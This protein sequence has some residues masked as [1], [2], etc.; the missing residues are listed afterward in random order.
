[1]K[2]RILYL[3]AQLGAGGLERQLSYLLQ[4]IDRERHQ[5]AVVVWNYNKD[6]LYVQKISELGIPL[7]PLPSRFNKLEKLRAFRNLVKTCHP[8]IVHSYSFYTNFAVWF[9]TLKTSAIPIG[10]IRQNFVSERQKAG[11]VLGRLSARWPATQIC[12]SEAAK[13][14]VERTRGCAK[15]N[16]VFVV[17]NRLDLHQFHCSP[18][19]TGIPHLLAVG[20][21]FPEKRWDRLLKG[22]AVLANRGLKFSLNHAGEGPLR[23]ELEAM[24]RQL[25]LQGAVHF[26][27]LSHDVPTLLQE[28][29]FLVH[30]SDDEGC[31]N[32]V[33]EAMACG[34]AIVATDAGDVPLL[35]D[36]GRTGFLVPRGDEDMLVEA[37]VKLLSDHELVCRMGKAGRTKAEQDFGVQHLAS[38][39]LAVYRMAGWKET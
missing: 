12:N 39:T 7:H 21:L 25:G 15:P 36:D 11:I 10:S 16:S 3:V 38:E 30:T 14:T 27:G 20:R 37:L 9:A 4:A 8:E 35:I 1:M 26:L 32:V 19:P 22:L 34:R 6:D 24:T 23:A 29:T 28:A 18:V 13:T 33:M 2:C 31:P 5:S 17:R